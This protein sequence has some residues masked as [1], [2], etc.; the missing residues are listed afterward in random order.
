MDATKLFLEKKKRWKPLSGNIKINVNELTAIK[1]NE[2]IENEH[3]RAYI[4][5]LKQLL[6][7]KLETLGFP[8]AE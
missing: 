6:D 3:Q 8:Q 1:S 5:V 4:Q 2:A 7:Q